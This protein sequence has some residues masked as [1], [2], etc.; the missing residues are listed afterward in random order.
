MCAKYCSSIMNDVHT[1]CPA[2]YVSPP[3]KDIQPTAF[4]LKKKAFFMA[5][6]LATGWLTE[7]SAHE[8][9]LNH[10]VLD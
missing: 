2:N 7:G 3:A 10:N 1:K 9:C 4:F 5:F 6:V 8:V